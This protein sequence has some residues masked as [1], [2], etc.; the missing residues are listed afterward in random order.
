MRILG[1]VALFASSVCWAKGMVSFDG[2]V[3]IEKGVS[4]Y[5]KVTPGKP[6]APIFVLLNGLT[7]DTDHWKDVVP[8]LQTHGATIVNIDLALQGRSMVKRF[9]EKFTWTTPVLKPL[10]LRGGAWDQEPVFQPTSVEA[11]AKYVSV[12]LKKLGITTP[13][14]LV[15]LSYGGG[16][17]LQ[18]AADYPEQVS[19][20]VLAAP[21][22]FPLPQQDDLIRFLV[23]YTKQLYPVWNMV[24]DDA[25]YDLILR[26]LVIS[27]Y[28]SVEP[29][30][31][32]WKAPFQ[33]MAASELVRGIRHL[34]YG[35]L[36]KRVK[37]PLHLV[38]AGKDAYIPADKLKEFWATVPPAIHG[39][40]LEIDGVEHKINESVGP[41]FASWLWEL[42]SNSEYLTRPGHFV[43]WPIK[44]I[45]T[46]VDGD[47]VIPLTKAQPCEFQL[48]GPSPLSPN[49]AMDR[50]RRHP[51]EAVQKIINAANPFGGNWR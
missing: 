39:S 32:K 36:L 3:D 29:E 18:M 10:V 46:E 47:R 8:S 1:W 40:W 38:M 48:V 31:T 5:A 21:F 25:I 12:L 28:P 30:I 51:M 9:N 7:Q 15:G 20:A 27:T 26:G 50:I 23:T 6:G 2:F 43:G 17:G 13:V 41:F 33:S 22:V 37:V 44:G 42:G 14:T 19:S 34:N 11:Q 4:L 35:E 16:L 24:P 45:A 49:L